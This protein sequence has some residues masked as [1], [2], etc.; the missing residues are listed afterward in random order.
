MLYRHGMSDYENESGQEPTVGTPEGGRPRR[1]TP[2]GKSTL[3]SRLAASPASIARAVVAQLKEGASDTARPAPTDVHAAAAHGT[4]GSGGSLPHLAE[5]QRAFGHPDVTGVRAHV[6]GAAAE[7]S[8]AMGARAYAAGDSVAFASSPD[9][10]LAAHEAAHVVQQRAG[11]RLSGGVGA[12]GD[13]YER[14]AD[15]VADGVVRGDFVQDLLGDLAHR[16]HAGGPA[17]QR[18]VPMCPP[19]SAPQ[20]SATPSGEP[21]P[22]H[23][24]DMR[25]RFNRLLEGARASIEARWTSMARLADQAA[26]RAV[27]SL[28]RPYRQ[29]IAEGRDYREGLTLGLALL[30]RAIGA[31]DSLA[32]AAGGALLEVAKYSFATSLRAAE[33]RVAGV[34]ERIVAD[35]QTRNNRTF[36]QLSDPIARAEVDGLHTQL[37]AWF[38]ANGGRADAPAF[39]A[40]AE[41]LIY[42]AARGDDTVAA[43]AQTLERTFRTTVAAIFSGR[44]QAEGSGPPPTF[45]ES[46]SGAR[47]APFLAAATRFHELMG[48]VVAHALEPDP[49]WGARE[50]LSR[51]RRN[52]GAMVEACHAGHVDQARTHAGVAAEALQSA[53]TALEQRLSSATPDV[54]DWIQRV[55]TIAVELRHTRAEAPPERVADP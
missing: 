47:G 32:G 43:L 11:V 12:A 34:Q 23:E 36:G 16:G 52:V 29:Q 44:T 20:E 21:D 55:G 4:S 54:A 38:S 51:A 26:A 42:P 19:S 31:A 25:Q 39:I 1:T 5:I 2:P 40:E 15:R 10:H 50:P 24:S 33:G 22:A 18:D 13:E 46:F 49:R 53:R 7:A 17:V 8:A 3:T 14:H 37:W 28:F 9:L 35:M 27:Q 30:Q 45:E 41:R 6:G 48:D